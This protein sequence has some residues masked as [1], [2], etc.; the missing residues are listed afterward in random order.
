MEWQV[1]YINILWWMIYELWLSWNELLLYAMIYWY[2]QDWKNEY[3]WSL[4]YIQNW[5]QLSRPSVI[6]LLKKLQGKW[7]I[8]KTKDSHYIT[9]KESLPPSKESLPFDSKE[10]LLVASK[11]TLPNIYNNINNTINNKKNTKKEIL[12]EDIIYIYDLYIKS[13]EWKWKYNLK[14]HKKKLWLERIK[15]ALSTYSK[16][17]LERAIW[18]Y[19]RENSE[20]ISKWYCKMIQYFFWPIERTSIYY[21]EEY[22]E[23]KEL[24]KREIIAKSIWF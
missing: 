23:S 2:T 11:E 16:E 15:K 4:T 18:N 20:D 17:I 9:S 24:P 12:E 3:H 19:I 13:V 8:E 5:L 21:Y 6:S 14:H 1:K 10:S 7:Y 22:L